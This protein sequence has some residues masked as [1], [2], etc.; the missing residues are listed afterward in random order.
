MEAAES[1]RQ[2]ER[3]RDEAR[4]NVVRLV[5]ERNEAH[6]DGWESARVKYGLQSAQA[7]TE[8]DEARAIAD[9]LGHLLAHQNET[10]GCGAAES[11]ED[12]IIAALDAWADEEK[13][14]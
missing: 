7:R 10:C 13:K 14:R 4:A 6:C 11:H 3:E 8:R 9:E 1:M 12:E 5:A 2:L